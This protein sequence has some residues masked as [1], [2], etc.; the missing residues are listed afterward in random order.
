MYTEHEYDIDKMNDIAFS[1]VL[2]A[3]L[4]L[5]GVTV[6]LGVVCLI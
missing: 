5:A 4:L 6:I 3:G 2:L 1:F